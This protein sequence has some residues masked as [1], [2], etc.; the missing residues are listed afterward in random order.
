MVAALG[1]GVVVPMGTVGQ[2]RG[3]GTIGGWKLRCGG[4]G[5]G[6]LPPEWVMAA[7]S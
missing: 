6:R 3:V 1:L 7:W 4:T 2:W 5:H